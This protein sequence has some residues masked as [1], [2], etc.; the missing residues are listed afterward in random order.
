[1]SPA[2][3]CRD[4][5]HPLAFFDQR[6][7]PFADVLVEFVFGALDLFIQVGHA[8]FELNLDLLDLLVDLGALLV[9]GF[10]QFL[11]Q[12]LERLLARVLID[13]GD[14]V[15]RKIQHAVQVPAADVQQQPQ[16]GGHAAG[17]PD[18]RDRRRQFNV[19]HALTADRGARHFHAAF[20]ADHAAMADV[21]VLPAVA[22][23]I[24][25]RSEDRL[26]EEAVLLRAQA[27]GS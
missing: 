17:I 7:Q 26:A 18:V 27:G 1:M 14:D 6:I 8:L 11:I 25:R 16:V 15:L 22:L 9:F 4:L 5:L 13:M 10:R 21:L 3:P 2:F 24:P 23:P 12:P 20:V 19:P